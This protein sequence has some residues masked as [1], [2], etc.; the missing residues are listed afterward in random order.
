MKNIFW[1][2]MGDIL[3]CIVQFVS[4]GKTTYKQ[5]I[6]DFINIVL[7]ARIL[8]AQKNQGFPAFFSVE[9]AR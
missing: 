1:D 2:E 8:K 4:L 3:Y 5:C 7:L 6:F 9:R